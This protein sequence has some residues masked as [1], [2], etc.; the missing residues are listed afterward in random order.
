MWHLINVWDT[1]F[2]LFGNHLFGLIFGVIDSFVS[3]VD[4]IWRISTVKIKHLFCGFF[5]S[6]RRIDPIQRPVSEF[7]WFRIGA[8]KSFW[9]HK[10]VPI[11]S[12]LVNHFFYL[13]NVVFFCVLLLLTA[14]A[15]D[16]R[17][18]LFDSFLAKTLNSWWGSYGRFQELV[19]LLGLQ[20][21]SKFWRDHFV[22]RTLYCVK[23]VLSFATTIFVELDFY[24]ILVDLILVSESF[25][26]V[27]TPLF[28]WLALIMGIFMF[29]WILR[30]H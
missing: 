18:I 28:H 14:I 21:V 25:K 11:A 13:M 12:I 27:W 10:T 16:R 29:M 24:L 19:F 5:V 22:R 2:E 23:H 17:N 30:H 26:Y 8:C 15:F 1:W 20:F 6:R 3:R 7:D 4:Q 9:T